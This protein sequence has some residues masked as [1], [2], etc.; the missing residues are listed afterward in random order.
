MRV[1][2]LVFFLCVSA[3][4]ARAAEKITV[5]Q[6]DHILSDPHRKHDKDLAKQLSGLELSER[7]SSLRLAKMHAGLPGN[8]SRLALL[9]LADASV[10]LPLPAAE[11]LQTAPP[12][13]E[14]QLLILS[15]AAENLVA[16]VHKLPDFFAR[17]TTTRFNDLKVSSVGSEPVIVEHQPFQY[18]DTFSDVVY[19]RNG[20]EVDEARE[21][22]AKVK[23]RPR[24]GLENWGVFGPLLR[25]VVT[26][27]YKGK[28]EWSHW[29]QRDSGP[30]AVFQYAVPKENSNYI[31]KYCCLGVFGAEWHSFESVP[32]FHGE[33]AIDP[34]TGA[35]YRLVLITA[36]LPSDPIFQAEI[37]VDYGPVEIG[38]KTYICPRKSVTITT[39]ISPIAEGGHCWGYTGDSG[40]SDCVPPHV[41][42]HVVRLLPRLSIRI[43][44]F[45]L[46]SPQSLRFPLHWISN[47]KPSFARSNCDEVL[48]RRE[49]VARFQFN[50]SLGQRGQ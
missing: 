45:A 42:R 22:E 39:A 41:R 11:I 28:M 19:Y 29:E 13:A 4:P 47:S 31:V 14:T 10:F 38:G 12:D 32:A 27:I 43:E 46:K 30:V 40:G 35:A 34:A 3:L 25:I 44:D 33:I 17:K 50:H 21:K 23:S 9:A 7:L 36:M 6:L 16:T 26:D 37:M 20:Q 18:R 5:E 15:R 48:T 8:N 49:W 1:F 24:N 2:L